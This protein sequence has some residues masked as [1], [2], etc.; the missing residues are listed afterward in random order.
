M[1]DCVATAEDKQAGIHEPGCTIR[2]GSADDPAD[3]YRH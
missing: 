2:T 1:C 3:H